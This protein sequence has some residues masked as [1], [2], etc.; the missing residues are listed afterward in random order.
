MWRMEPIPQTRLT[1]VSN[2]PLATYSGMLPGVLAGQ[3]DPEAMEIDLVRLCAATGARLVLGEVTGLDRRRQELLFADRPPLRYDALSIGIG[4][5]PS[6]EGLEVADDTLLP[7]KPMQTLLARLAA[8]LQSG[9]G[10][11]P[12]IQILVVGGGVGGVE[13]AFC[14]PATISKLLP[15]TSLTLTL[16]DSHARLVSGT[17]D[18][19]AQRVRQELER[20]G[21]KLIL[22]RRVTRIEKGRVTLDDGQILTADLVLW[23]TSAAAPPLLKRLGLPT[24]DRGFLLTRPTLQS[25]ADDRVFAVGDSGTIAAHSTPKA[26]VYAVRQGPFLWDNLRRLIAGEPLREYRPQS[27]FLKLINTGDNR[28]IGEYRGFTFAGG[29]T[30]RLKDRI[31]RKFMAMY[32]DYRPMMAGFEDEDDAHDNGGKEVRQMR[33]LGCGGKVGGNVLA[34]VLARLEIPS[35]PSVPLGLA[36]PD[37]VALIQQANGQP[38]AVT[39]DFFAPPLDDPYL[40]GRIA[41]LH[42]ASDVLAKGARPIAALAIATIPPGSDDQQEHL[43][44]DLLAGGLAEFKA[45]G[46]TLAGGHTIEGPQTMIGYTIVGQPHRAG[47]AQTIRTKGGLRPGDVLIVTK[48]LGIGVLLAAHMQARLRAEW[49]EPLIA[50]LLASNQPAADVLDDFDVLAAT[51]VTGFGLGGHLFE[52]LRA[53]GASAELDLACIPLL[54][55]AAELLESGLEST[56]A[57]SNRYTVGNL[58]HKGEA[59]RSRLASLFDPQTCGGLLFG[60]APQAAPAILARLGR[61]PTP[62]VVIGSV[63]AGTG[64]P[65]LR[66]L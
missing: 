10:F 37:D 49:Y 31:D 5:I 26:G 15:G 55:G 30:W 61:T 63:Q 21:T 45:M 36:A 59:S 41:A 40:V 62:G 52:M 2:F 53:S 3:Y 33:C 25:T 27:S 16:V 22:G 44:Y 54:P 29:W 9:A 11:Q 14:L 23:A 4:S 60:A 12:A 46:A 24:D 64:E 18:Q 56:L 7:I 47:S 28:A 17:T 13:V 48:P 1:C 57:P 38:L 6:R 66:L 58:E 35:H 50:A 42:A 19:T 34:R 43:L 65:R 39:T 8:R 20:R 51:D 32:Q